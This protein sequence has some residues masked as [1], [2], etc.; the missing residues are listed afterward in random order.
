MEK[1]KWLRMGRYGGCG[2]GEGLGLAA[3]EA[4][5]EEFFSI[6]AFVYKLFF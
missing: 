6:S 5:A 3:G 1:L 2:G 4:L